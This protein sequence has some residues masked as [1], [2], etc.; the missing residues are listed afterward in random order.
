MVVAAK[1]DGGS[2]RR[3][4][5]SAL[6]AVARRRKKSK[7]IGEDRCYAAAMAGLGQGFRK[8]G[9]RMKNRVAR[10]VGFPL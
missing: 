9:K 4:K 8:L 1:E 6:V 10:R 5:S 3:G 7:E 2:R